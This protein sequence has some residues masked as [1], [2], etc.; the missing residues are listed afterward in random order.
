MIKDVYD[1]RDYVH[2]AITAIC[3]KDIDTAADLLVDA[4][5]DLA[6]LIEEIDD[7]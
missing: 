7:E 2:D 4:N 6:R 1:I 5:N 3:D